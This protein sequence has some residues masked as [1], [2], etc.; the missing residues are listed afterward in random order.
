MYF[1]TE[2]LIV[3]WDVV[4]FHICKPPLSVIENISS[5]LSVR[6]HKPF[7]SHLVSGASR[8]VANAHQQSICSFFQGQQLNWKWTEPQM[9][10]FKISKV[11]VLLFV[12]RPP[13]AGLTWLS[14][15]TLPGAGGDPE[16][17]SSS[18]RYRV[19][20]WVARVNWDQT[21]DPLVTGWCATSLI[22]LHES[23]E[24]V[25]TNTTRKILSSH[26]DFLPVALYVYS[27]P[28]FI[29]VSPPLPLSLPL[30]F[31]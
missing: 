21:W 31:C 20:L 23:W 9:G 26:T 22:E 17:F 16:P 6:R 15:A 28:L 25:F 3:K 29:L 27:S 11:E 12:W 13:T 2:W 7:L 14:A 18:L 8:S 1:N 19:N 4:Y 30:S 5:V 24:E 10:C